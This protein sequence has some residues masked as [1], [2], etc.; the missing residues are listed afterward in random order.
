MR[1]TPLRTGRAVFPHPALR[2]VVLPQ[3]GL[4]N[5]TPREDRRD[6]PGPFPQIRIPEASLEVLSTA[7]ALQHC[8]PR[9]L[10]DL[11]E[12]PTG[13]TPRV[14]AWVLLLAGLFPRSTFLPPFAPRALPRFFAPMAALPPR[15]FSPRNGA[16]LLHV[17]VRRS[18]SATKHPGRPVVAFARYPSAQQASPLFGRSG[19]RLSYADSPRFR[20]NRVRYPADQG[21]VSRC[22]PP[23][24][25]AKQFRSTTGR[26]APA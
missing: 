15:R 10:Y 3:S 18:R 6:R 9:N 11:R 22:S 19:F 12:A 13:L 16:S 2:S 20:P 5:R 1:R 24:L 26:R 8:F 7:D 4:T 17:H 25:A 23:R 14:L 21:L